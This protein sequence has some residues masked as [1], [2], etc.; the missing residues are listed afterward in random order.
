MRESVPSRLTCKACNPVDSFLRA[1]PASYVKADRGKGHRAIRTQVTQ[2][3]DTNPPLV[4]RRF[5]Y[6]T[7]LP[8]GLRGNDLGEAS[9]QTQY[10]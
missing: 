6:L 8:N 4:G 3:H 7:P 9:M 1:G 10:M 5:N 2:S